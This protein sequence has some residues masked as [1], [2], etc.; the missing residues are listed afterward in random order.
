MNALQTRQLHTSSTGWSKKTLPPSFRLYQY[1]LEDLAPI[2]SDAVNELLKSSLK[3]LIIDVRSFSYYSKCRIR[4]AINISIPSV[5]LKRPSYTLEKIA[6]SIVSREAADRF[7]QFH[8][9]ATHIIFYDHASS[10]PSD[11]GNSATA[12]LLG[13]KLRQAG[14]KGPLNYLQGGLDTFSHLYTEQCESAPLES[15]RSK[16]IK[17]NELVPSNKIM[18]LPLPLPPPTHIVLPTS[19]KTTVVN[20]FFTNIRQNLELSHGPL[21]ERFHIRLPPGLHHKDGVIKN[22][23]HHHPTINSSSPPCYH[24]RYGLAGSTVDAQGNF[25]LPIWL[26]EMIKLDNGPKKLAEMYEKLE[27][28]EQTRLSTIMK[29]HTQHNDRPFPFSIASSMEKGAL[30]RYTNIWPY[31]YSRVK[32]K[33]NKDDYINANRIQF[34]SIK[35]DIRSSTPSRNNSKQELELEQKGLLSETSVYTMNN[36]ATATDLICQ[37]PYISTQGPLPTT[38][39]DFWRMVWD[40]N[41]SVIV[42]LTQE[43]EMNKIK[44]HRYWPSTLGIPQTYGSLTVTLLSESKQAVHNLN[45]KRVHEDECIIIRKLSLSSSSLTREITQLQYMGWTDFGT[46]D[47]PLGLL[48]VVHLADKAHETEGPMIVHCSAGCGRSGT[49]CVI[50]TMIQRLWHERDIFTNQ[51]SMHDLIWETVCRFREQRMSMVQTHRQFVFCYE[52]ILWWLLGHG[53]LP[54]EEQN[55]TAGGSPGPDNSSSNNRSPLMVAGS[56]HTTDD[57]QGSSSVGS[58]LDDFKELL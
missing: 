18:A 32:L 27:R 34:A 16:R 22:N 57:E 31:E 7:M 28:I 3:L 33:N 25:I 12:I 6:E 9:T 38:Y 56:H 53:Y 23:H 49:F 44:C 43:M 2:E 45:D 55:R 46:P 24:P 8:K 15:E 1:I 42:M 29:Y 37:R 30:N 35:Q 11:S 19:N 10:K 40:E 5:L 26:R 4:T 58:M 54:K 51:T 14:Y 48:Q 13:S 17:S 39:N 47:R 21:Q 41:S 20:P 50:D 36:S 52:A